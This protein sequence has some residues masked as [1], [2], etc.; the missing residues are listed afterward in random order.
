MLEVRLSAPL[1]APADRVW[2]VVGDF[3]GMARWHPFVRESVLEPAPGGVGRRVRVVG[4]TGEPREL[5]ERLVLYDAAARHLA[6]AIVA[7]PAPFR[8]YVGHFRILADGADRCV[9]DYRGT[10]E[11][12]EG[13]SER[14][15]IERV[16]S[17]YEAAR[18]NLE[19][20]F[21]R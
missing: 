7:G 6:Y 8:N 15:A 11:T 18:E 20:L 4:G 9:W 2:D 16:R 12:A 14:D 1:A 3:G 5:T 13:A 17:F 21:G 19:S 10:F